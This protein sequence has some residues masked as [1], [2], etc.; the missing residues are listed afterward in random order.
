MKKILFVLVA[1]MGFTLFAEENYDEN[2]F[3]WARYEMYCAMLGVE[4]TYEQYEY[5]CEHPMC[6]IID[7]ADYD[8]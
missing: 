4:P 7:E 2:E 1:L 8:F 3:T 6:L 5:L